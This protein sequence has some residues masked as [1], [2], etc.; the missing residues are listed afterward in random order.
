M[1]ARNGSPGHDGQSWRAAATMVPSLGECS[2]GMHN[3]DDHFLMP[4]TRLYASNSDPLQRQKVQGP[5]MQA[6]CQWSCA[7]DA[8]AGQQALPGQCAL[9]AGLLLYGQAQQAAA[10]EAVG[11]AVALPPELLGCQLQPFAM[12]G[13][14]AA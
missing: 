8:I 1:L 5:P 9:P 13:N 10:E 3:R 14:A 4:M 2:G 6:G 12:Q 11:L 7:R